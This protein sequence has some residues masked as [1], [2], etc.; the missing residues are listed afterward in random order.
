MK[1]SKYR[2]ATIIHWGSNKSFSLNTSIS[3]VRKR[4]PDIGTR[5]LK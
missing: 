5:D 3:D 1:S 2:V 4:Q